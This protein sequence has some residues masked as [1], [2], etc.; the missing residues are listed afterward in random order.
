MYAVGSDNLGIDFLL[1]VD[2]GLTDTGNEYHVTGVVVE[3][4]IG[5][6]GEGNDTPV[7]AVAAIA[8]GSVLVADVG[9]ATQHLLARS[10]L[11]ASGTVTRLVGKYARTERGVLG[12]ST[13]L[14]ECVEHVLR[15][16]AVAALEILC[17]DALAQTYVLRNAA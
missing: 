7:D 10:G 17:L 13:N 3:L 8:L 5:S 15:A 1:T 14:C 6:D 2:D 12:L 4:N 11:L 9:V 16:L